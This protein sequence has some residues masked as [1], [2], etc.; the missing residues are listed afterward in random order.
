MRII[1]FAGLFLLGMCLVSGCRGKNNAELEVVEAKDGSFTI[2]MPGKPEY[3]NQKVAIGGG[4]TI[5]INNYDL[6]TRY[7]NYTAG[8]SEYP[9][10]FLRTK[11]RNAKEIFD[12]AQQATIDKLGG[13]VIHVGDLASRGFPQ[14]TFTLKCYVP[15][16]SGNMILRQE[17][18]LVKGRMY[19]IQSLVFVDKAEKYKELIDEYH[20]SLVLNP[21]AIKTR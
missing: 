16:S 14:R 10:G 1:S 5:S 20:D 2:K 6:I 13:T 18:Y 19:I 21:N 7:I 12:S 15:E 17:S 8:Y 9:R 4:A 11:G 3:I